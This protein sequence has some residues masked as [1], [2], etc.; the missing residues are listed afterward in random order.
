MLGHTGSNLFDTLMV[1]LKGIFD[2]VDFEIKTA[3]N[4]T[5]AKLSNIL[6]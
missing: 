2:K 3:D 1:F 5:H 6:C 4:K